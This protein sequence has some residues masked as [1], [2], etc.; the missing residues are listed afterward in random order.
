M[1][2]RFRRSVGHAIPLLDA[3]GYDHCLLLDR[4]REGLMQAAHLMDAESGRNMT[5]W[6]NQPGLQLYTT[7]SLPG[8]GG[9]AIC[10]EPQAPPGA[11]HHPDLGD[12]MVEEGETYCH[13]TLY[14]FF[15]TA[16]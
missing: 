3:P 4:E 9:G 5:I 15:T 11:L 10:L 8:C 13:K 6:T 1:D 7:P 2:F 12:L 14:C 16:S